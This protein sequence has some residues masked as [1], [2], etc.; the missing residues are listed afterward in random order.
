M[1]I[2]PSVRWCRGQP[3]RC[4]GDTAGPCNADGHVDLA[5]ASER[6]LVAKC[7]PGA[8]IGKVGGSAAGRDDGTVFAI[9]S[10]CIVSLDQ[11]TTF[12]FVGVNGAVP[13]PS[14]LLESI[15]VEISGRPAI[16]SLREE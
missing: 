6:L 1:H 9:G 12:L 14:H 11:K 15:T 10:R 7:A 8:L 4:L 5:L 13:R 3:W 16:Y 2:L